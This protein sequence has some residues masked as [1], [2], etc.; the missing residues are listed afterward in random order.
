MKSHQLH[1]VPEKIYL[2]SSFTGQFWDQLLLK[3]PITIDIIIVDSSQKYCRFINADRRHQQ[4]SQYVHVSR[5]GAYST[6]HK[7][8]DLMSQ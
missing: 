1:N 2:A 7:P 8:F 3:S 4:F 5:L 6:S